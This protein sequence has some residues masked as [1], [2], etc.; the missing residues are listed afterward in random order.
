MHVSVQRCCVEG[1]VVFKKKEDE[2][3][4]VRYC[5]LF[6]IRSYLVFRFLRFVV[7]GLYGLKEKKGKGKNWFLGIM[8][9]D[10]GLNAFFFFLFFSLPDLVY[11]LP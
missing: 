11:L 1:V 3:M 7:V 10:G 5:L 8:V 4:A 9:S 6:F 2:R